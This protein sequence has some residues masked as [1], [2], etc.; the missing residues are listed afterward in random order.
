MRIIVD[1][2]DTRNDSRGTVAW[3]TFLAIACLLLPVMIASSYEF[4][5]T[6]DEKSRHRYGEM[7]WEFLR[8]LR[9]RD[10]FVLDG[11]EM[12]G[13][14]FDTICAAIERY[15]PANRYVVRH[16]VNATFG[17][18]GIVYCGRLASRLFGRWAGVLALI[19]LTLSPRYFGDSMNNPKDLPFA[20]V[21]VAALYYMS[22]ISPTWPYL[23]RR[24]AIKATIVLALALN[25]RAAGLMYLG[26]LGL[27]VIGYT[28]AEGRWQWRRQA[29]TAARLAAV[30]LGVLVLGTAF[31][32]WAQANPLTRPIEALVGFAN[33]PYVADMLFR[34]GV[35]TTDKLPWSYAPWWL[36]IS[37]PPVVL[38]GLLLA[39]VFRL[40][41]LDTPV[42]L[43]LALVILPIALVIA[44]SSTLYDGVRHLLF[45]YP[46]LVA[47]AA[48]GWIAVLSPAW[49]AWARRTA[50]AAL[51]AGIVNVL[52]FTVR[53][54]PNEAT[55]F[56]EIVGGPRGAF[57]KYDM[58][59][60]GNCLL[61]AV[62]WSATAAE[63]SGVPIAISGE[64]WQ[65]IQLD[66]ERFHQLY[67]TLPYRNQHQIDVRLARGSKE[68]VE[69]LAARADILHKVTTPDGAVLCVVVPGPRFSELQPH[70][71]LP[72]TDLSPRQLLSP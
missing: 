13:G 8:G 42:V 52:I 1:Q 12:Y 65:V 62:A 26:Y 17:W 10:E 9:G 63:R 4:G 54:H 38:V 6:W 45:V 29:D 19:L 55:Y 3:W 67:F 69:G 11:G 53:A 68:G 56:N 23:S 20:A 15:I 39:A 47:I 34:G 18:A 36:L 60:W 30:T 7:I 48:A 58:D 24:A 31:W 33:F 70:L 35:V 49:P 41:R 72:P 5:V 66:A 21:A 16:A 50:G 57:A 22:T 37:T 71:T 25:I 28:I 59:Y 32:P 2:S 43:L 40:S 61:E 27:L 51:A 64:P 14:L 44:M 46:L